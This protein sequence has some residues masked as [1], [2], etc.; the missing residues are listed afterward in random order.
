MDYVARDKGMFT[1]NGLDVT[2]VGPAMTGATALQLM[3]ADNL[4]VYPLDMFTTLQAIAGNAPVKVVACL[5][6]RSVYVM[7]ASNS[8]NL[9][10]ISAPFNDRMKA[11]EGKTVGVTGIGAGT[12]R[13]LVSALAAASVP[14]DQVHRIGIG[15]P[16]AAIG[17]FKAGK[18]DVYVTGSYSGAYQI[19]AAVPGTQMFA[20]TGDPG[21]PVSLQTFAQSVWTASG[22]WVSDHPDQVSAYRK[23]LAQAE[24]WIIAHPADAAALMNF[25]MYAGGD[26]ATAT[27]AVDIEIADYYKPGSPQ[28]TCGTTG[29]DAAAATFEQQGLGKASQ[30]KFA[31]VVASG[32]AS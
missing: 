19:Q 4:Q 30:F 22:K 18:I 23:A 9:P 10:P 3:A 13:A 17:Q 29:F 11:L 27:K 20:D 16:A 12:D 26:L 5:A 6:P 8:A 21:S 25:D 15:A 32:V 7:V 14:L 31:N 28:L 2:L 1:D 24:A